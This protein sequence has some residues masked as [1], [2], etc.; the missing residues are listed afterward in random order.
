MGK[1]L[2]K[3]LGVFCVGLLF[4]LCG[5]TA[6]ASANETLTEVPYLDENGNSV[7][8]EADVPV[9]V[10]TEN[11]TEW[12]D[13][14]YVVDNTVNMSSRIYV[15]GSVHLILK[16]DGILYSDQ[17]IN[18]SNGNSITIYSQQYDG[19][20]AVGKLNCNNQ[21]TGFAA[22]GGS[23][24]EAGGA[25]IINGGDIYSQSSG[26]GAAIGGGYG[27]GSGSITIN[28]G[29]IDVFASDG[30]AGIGAGYHGNGENITITGGS[31]QASGG[32]DSLG[33]DAAG[34]GGGVNGAGG[35]ITITGGIIDRASSIGSG[36]NGSACSIT[37]DGS[38][39]PASEDPL[40]VYADRINAPG[41]NS[42]VD[43][44]GRVQLSINKTSAALHCEG[45]ITITDA[46][47]EAGDRF[48]LYGGN[49]S[50]LNSKVPLEMMVDSFL[51]N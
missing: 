34:I 24:D 10:V 19:S 15:R 4:A 43:I 41:S 27:A 29:S 12:T 18:V 44:Q 20:K 37:L 11:M 3:L 45:K 32:Q 25:I 1:K 17:G 30:A 40:I 21:Q 42:T 22:I 6:G 8:T 35:S 38:A 39:I 48:E 33:N 16:N 7:T 5:I 47:V 50:I 26:G 13:G 14:W 28:G 31:I 49:I 51:V 9:T 23:F 36:E 2:S 46:E